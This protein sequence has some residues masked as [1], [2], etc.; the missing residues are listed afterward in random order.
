M[1]EIHTTTTL[2]SHKSNVTKYVDID[3]VMYKDV[4]AKIT[5]K[6][7]SFFNRQ[8]TTESKQVTSISFSI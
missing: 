1:I 4:V 5:A 6:P 7:Y 2:S 3:H 8:R